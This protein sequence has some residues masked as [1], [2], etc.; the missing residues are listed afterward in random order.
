MSTS[1][2]DGRAVRRSIRGAL[3]AGYHA[4]AKGVQAG[5]A[6]G[7]LDVD[8]ALHGQVAVAQAVPTQLVPT[9]EMAWAISSTAR[10]SASGRYGCSSSAISCT[11]A[12]RWSASSRRGLHRRQPPRSGRVCVSRRR[13]PDTAVVMPSAM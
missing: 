13:R 8:H 5:Q 2:C 10:S 3:S 6:G 12:S 9:P 1:G 11:V 4:I 7:D